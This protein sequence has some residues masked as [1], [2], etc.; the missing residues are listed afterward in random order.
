MRSRWLCKDDCLT[1]CRLAPLRTCACA[2]NR[3][4]GL[5]WERSRRGSGMRSP[6]GAVRRARAIT[7]AP[8]Q[9][10]RRIVMPGARTWAPARGRACD[11]R[12]P[13]AERA[14]ES[15]A[16]AARRRRGDG[17]STRGPCRTCRRYEVAAPITAY[18][19][20]A[21]GGAPATA[22]ISRGG[23]WAWPGTPATARALQGGPWVW[24]GT[25]ITARAL[26]DVPPVRHY[27]RSSCSRLGHG[28]P[29]RP[30]RGHG[31]TYD[32]CM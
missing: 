17:V 26:Q 12:G 9:R 8:G 30:Y 18:V 28:G 6:R 7:R 22:G 5:S 20:L 4:G 32:I 23:P 2:T 27:A 1:T 13:G 11:G 16:G 24:P 14:Q 29:C 19:P 10:S 15:R 3:E 25:P 31:A 21:H